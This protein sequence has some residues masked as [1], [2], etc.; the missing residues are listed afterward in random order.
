[1]GQ[2]VII[3]FRGESGLLSASINQLTTFCRSFAHY[4]Y[5][6]LCSAIVHFNQNNFLYFVCY[7][8]SAQTS[9][10]RWFGKHGY[11]VKLWRYKQRTPNTNDTIGQWMNPHAW[12]FSACDTESEWDILPDSDSKRKISRGE[13]SSFLPFVYEIIHFNGKCVKLA[14]RGPN[15]A[16]HVFSCGARNLNF[17]ASA[18]T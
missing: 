15:V 1:L 6:R 9:P 13:L 10:N 8:W 18:H 2:K 3:R 11:D 17:L 7:G 5:L 16:R 14:A 12:K 4:P